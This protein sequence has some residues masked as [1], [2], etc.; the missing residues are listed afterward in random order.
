MKH[1]ERS[2]G[3]KHKNTSRD[4]RAVGTKTPREV[5]GHESGD[6]RPSGNFRSNLGHDTRSVCGHRCVQSGPWSDWLFTP[7]T[8]PSVIKVQ[9]MC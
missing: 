2:Q 3:G 9:Q 8:S 5:T 1:P 7:E 6:L 4:H